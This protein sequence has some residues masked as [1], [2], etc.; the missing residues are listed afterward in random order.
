MI[1]Y[2]YPARYLYLVSA[3]TLCSK[4]DFWL[5]VSPCAT[6]VFQILL[7]NSMWEK[8]KQDVAAKKCFSTCGG[9]GRWRVVLAGCYIWLHFAAF[10]S[11][12][13]CENQVVLVCS[14]RE[15][16]VILF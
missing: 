12:H 4:I 14:R 13:H 16:L 1:V 7:S 11:L 10:L 8:T 6:A 15:S 5:V 3:S 9:E 2:L